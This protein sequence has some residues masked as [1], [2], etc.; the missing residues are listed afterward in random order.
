MHLKW[1]T[2]I[3]MWDRTLGQVRRKLKPG[4]EMTCPVDGLDR[5]L[6]PGPDQRKIFG[7]LC[8]KHG[9][10]ITCWRDP[11]IRLELASDH[12]AQGE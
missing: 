5:S 6:P 3:E 7:D 12:Q 2:P 11:H 4:H 10:V 1:E 9:L 8:T